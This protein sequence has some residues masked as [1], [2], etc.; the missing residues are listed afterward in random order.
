MSF[1]NTKFPEQQASHCDNINKRHYTLS[2]GS[3]LKGSQDTARQPKC[4]RSRTVTVIVVRPIELV[5]HSLNPHSVSLRALL[6]STHSLN[7][8]AALVHVLSHSTHCLT[9]HTPSL[10][11]LSHSM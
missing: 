11:A 4:S 10:H 5:E 3:V 1:F 7:L 8:C 9:P 2:N 6:N